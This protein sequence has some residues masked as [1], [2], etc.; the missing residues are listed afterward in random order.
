MIQELQGLRVVSM[1]GIF[2]YHADIILKGNFFVTLFF[3]ISGFVLYYSQKDKIV[4]LNLKENLKW[5]GEKYTYWLKINLFTFIMSIFIRWNWVVNLEIHEAIIRGILSIFLIQTLIPEYA[6]SYNVLTWFLS[7]LFL[8]TLFTKPLIKLVNKINSLKKALIIVF[9]IQGF[10]VVFNSLSNL[11]IELYNNPFYRTFDI[12]A[13]MIIAKMFIERDREKVQNETKKE[14]LIIIAWIVFYLASFLS[15]KIRIG[16]NYYS[17]I[18]YL[19]VYYFALGQGKISKFLGNKRFQ[20]LANYSFEFYMVH[21]LI[22]IL[23][24]TNFQPYMVNTNIMISNIVIAI[25]AGAISMIL[26]IFLKKKL[27][28]KFIIQ[29]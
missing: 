5:V 8:I 23:L 13:G 29:L 10:I 4:K 6:M 11:N 24:K 17:I 7:V 21:E 27:S 12:L 18:F 22:L 20:K 19:V 16:L 15:D 3:I 9:L 25:L 14:Y 26:A 28:R 1:V 2:L